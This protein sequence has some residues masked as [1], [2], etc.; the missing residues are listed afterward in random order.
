ME[1]ISFCSAGRKLDN[2][3]IQHLALFALLPAGYMIKLFN[4]M[5]ILLQDID[6]IDKYACKHTTVQMCK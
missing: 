5:F 2:K 3:I 4:T 1:Y 6:M